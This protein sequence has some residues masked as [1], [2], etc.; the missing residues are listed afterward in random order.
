M[1]L[2]F[3]IASRIFN[4]RISASAEENT[5][6]S[7]LVR[8]WIYDLYFISF[9]SAR[10]YFIFWAIG[11]RQN[12]PIRNSSLPKVKNRGVETVV[13]NNPKYHCKYHRDFLIS[14]MVPRSW[15]VLYPKVK[16]YNS[17]DSPSL[18]RRN[19]G[20][21]TPI[22]YVSPKCLY[23]GRAIYGPETTSHRTLRLM[24]KRR[25]YSIEAIEIV[26]DYL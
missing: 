5:L 26:K 11:H 4:A 23:S 24:N 16:T 6:T 21:T 20:L 15:T 13:L 19:W 12:I 8:S 1:P 2:H 17:Q 22:F 10:T 7:S 9:T 25:Q 14:P 18:R 3:I